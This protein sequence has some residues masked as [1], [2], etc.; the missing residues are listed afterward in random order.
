MRKRVGRQQEKRR[1]EEYGEVMRELLSNVVQF[2]RRQLFYKQVEE[3]EAEGVDI[4]D[5]EFEQAYDAGDVTIETTP[6]DAS[7]A[8]AAMGSVMPTLLLMMPQERDVY[9]A[10]LL[11]AIRY[12]LGQATL[13]ATLEAHAAS[14]APQRREER[15]GEK[16]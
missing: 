8:W 13:A 1:R 4:T 3:Q 14:P 15:R 12:I 11:A 5:E 2:L 16:E 6:A 10:S 7:A 9:D